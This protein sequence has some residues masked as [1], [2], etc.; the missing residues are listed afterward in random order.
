M[1]KVTIEIVPYGIEFHERR[2]EI[3]TV[4]IGLKA[5][6]TGNIGHYES[7]METDQRGPEPPRKRIT[8]KHDRSLG[9]AELVRRCLNAHLGE[10]R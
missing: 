5:V 3:G 2:R 9:A 10:P 6:A 4:E 7:N 8:L 1:L